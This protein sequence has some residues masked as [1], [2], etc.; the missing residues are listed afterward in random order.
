MKFDIGEVLG[1]LYW[2]CLEFCMVCAII[3]IIIFTFIILFSLIFKSDGLFSKLLVEHFDITRV[4]IFVLAYII[5]VCHII[6]S[7]GVSGLYASLIAVSIILLIFIIH[8]IKKS[9]KNQAEE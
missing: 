9:Y 3:I 7:C 8:E 6:Y 2:L 4:S 1:V 5:T